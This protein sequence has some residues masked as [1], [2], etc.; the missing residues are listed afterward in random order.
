MAKPYG[1]A[2]LNYL[3]LFWEYEPPMHTNSSGALTSRNYAKNKQIYKK[4]HSKA[5]R[6]DSKAILQAEYRQALLDIEAE[7]YL[8][9]LH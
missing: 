6:R 7:E 5:R 1:P 9:Y 8:N 4:F 2:T 3:W